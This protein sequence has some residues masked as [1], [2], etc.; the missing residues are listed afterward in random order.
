M[1]N[2]VRCPACGEV[3]GGMTCAAC[4]VERPTGDFRDEAAASR[5]RA[6]ELRDRDAE[7]RDEL[8]R[9]EEQAASDRHQMAS[10]RDQMLS[11]RDQTASGRDQ[12]SADADQRSA[13]DE[14]APAATRLGITEVF[15]RGSGRVRSVAPCRGYAARRPGRGC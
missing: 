13:D 10:D 4:G 9:G 3:F 2:V 14:F 15:W 11:D 1:T 12:R 6:A 5:D 8:A 7:D